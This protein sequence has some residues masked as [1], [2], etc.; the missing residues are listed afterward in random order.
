MILAEATIR[1]R[2]APQDILSRTAEQEFLIWFHQGSAADN[3]TTV[4]RIVL[5]T[6][7]VDSLVSSVASATIALPPGTPPGHL[8]PGCAAELDRRPGLTPDPELEQARAY[9]AW[10]EHELPVDIEQI[11]GRG[12]QALPAV[13]CSLPA[14]VAIR[15]EHVGTKL[16]SEALGKLE[17]DILQLRVGL[18]VAQK[19]A[20]V[21]IPRSCFVPI[22][23]DCL[24][25]PRSRAAVVEVMAG[26]DTAAGGRLT[27]LLSGQF[28]AFRPARLQELVAPLRGRVRAVGL[29]VSTIADVPIEVLQRSFSVVSF[30]P[31]TLG[32]E[33]AE[34]SLW[35]ALDA[36]HRAG[37]KI[38]ARDVATPNQ[39][40]M[41]LELGVDFVCGAAP[42]AALI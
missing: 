41:L 29:A 25:S 36:I 32:G 5:L 40:R 12:G 2:L 35:K 31:G 9:L 14:S 17:L 27:L 18:A 21:N 4:A 42:A 19:A 15:L 34:A 37:A 28:C 33:Q 24:A 6:E 1:R 20:A 16:G 10:V 38:V 7:F 11:F 8:P 39:A 26:A 30:L 3:E 13:W 23:C 22:S